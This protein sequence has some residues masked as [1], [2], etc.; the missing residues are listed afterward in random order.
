[1][2]SALAAILAGGRGKRMGILCQNRAKPG[3]PFAG[4]Y[5]VM[6]Y[7]LSNCIHSQINDIIVLT[8]YLRS[9]MAD[10]LNDWVDTNGNNK[11]IHII[12]PVNSSYYGTADA[13]YQNIE[14]LKKS[15]ADLV[16][17]LAGD[18][19]Y[20]MDYQRMM[21]F[22][23]QMEAD[24]TVGVIGIPIEEAH[25]FGIV[26][27]DSQKRIQDFI[28]KPEFPESNLV[29]MGI[30]VFNKEVLIERLIEDA[31]TPH[32]PHDFGH[33]IIP[34]MV[35]TDKVAGYEFEGYWRDIGTPEAYYTSNMEVL[36]TSPLFSINDD[37]PVLTRFDHLATPV[38]SKK[39]N[40]HNSIIAP[41]CVINGRVDN[42]ILSPNVHVLKEAEIRNSII[43]S[44][45]SIGYHSVVDHCILDTGVKVDEFCYLGFEGSA[46]ADSWKV[47]ILGEGVTVPSHTAIC[48]NCKI[49]PFV[50]PDDFPGKVVPSNT[51]LS[52]RQA[53]KISQK[54]EKEIF[55]HVG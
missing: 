27:I 22:H 20:E 39:G 55:A 52:Q 46:T 24:V 3:L 41:G 19:V 6:D 42:S 11:I 10:Y 17:V 25:R 51:T 8:D 30:Y 29:S 13:V 47:T 40:V 7:T 33:A 49:L 36:G 12:E 44:D 14:Y 31:L 16:I 35:R 38:I 2:E 37:W 1:M 28:E 48:R 34:R 4:K 15:N 54:Y 9:D 23:R 21:A 50:G 5:C 18:H 53:S 32:S 43:M 26:T 45:C